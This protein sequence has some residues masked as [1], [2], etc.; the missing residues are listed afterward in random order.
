[1]ISI[2]LSLIFLIIFLTSKRNVQFY[3]FTLAVLFPFTF[4]NI[5]SI[6][7]VQIIE[8]LNPV[9][10]LIIINELIPIDRVK[11]NQQRLSFKGLELFVFAIIIL[12]TW[13]LV[14]YFNNQV[15]IEKFFGDIKATGITR[16][17]FNIFNTGL[18]FFNTIAFLKIHFDEIDLEAW[19]NVIIYTSLGIGLLRLIAFFLSFN[20]PFL[21]GL[22]NYGDASSHFG[23]VAIRLGGLTEVAGY[24]IAALLA[25]HYLVDKLNTILLIIFTLFLFMS[26]GRTYLVG[27][28]FAVFLYSILFAQKYIVYSTFMIL[29]VVIL[30]V[31]LVP[32]EV[33]EGQ[34]NRLTA[35][36]G[37]IKGQ[38][39]HRFIIYKLYIN[40]FLDNPLFGKG[41][42]PYKG[43]IPPLKSLQ[44]DFI[45]R[46]QFSGGHGSYLSMLSTFGIGGILYL[47]TMIF[48]GI[49]LAF[50]KIKAYKD[51]NP[52]LT[53]MLIFAFILLVAKSIYYITSYNGL[54]DFSL[55]LLVGVVASVRAIENEKNQI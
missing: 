22:Y 24:G 55:L 46:Q 5:K 31:L 52:K 21:S 7:N 30:I 29:I 19:L 26:G 44:V 32:T 1:M 42:G 2:A 41:I 12:F 8:W 39:M 11:K 10:F 43:F 17:Y 38:D 16:I 14:S 45:R 23:G 51:T 20:I 15:F 13:G 34:I 33:L 18:L 50:K 47:I 53:T 9:V 6:P 54:Q 37:G 48:G 40:N 27:L 3:L 4:G 25:K 28:S 36:K 35:F 49:S